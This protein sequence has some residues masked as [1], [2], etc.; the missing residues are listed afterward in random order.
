MH[1]LLTPRLLL[2]ATT[3]TKRPSGARIKM[4]KRLKLNLKLVKVTKILTHALVPF[5]LL[6]NISKD[7]K[8]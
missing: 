2:V 5:L 8:Q 1:N 3:S 7:G 4:D 6:R